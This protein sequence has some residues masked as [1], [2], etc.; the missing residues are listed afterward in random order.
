MSKEPKWIEQELPLAELIRSEDLKARDPDKT[1]ISAYARSYKNGDT[2]PPLKAANI[3]GALYLIDGWHRSLAAQKAGLVTLPVFTAKMTQGQAMA[4]AAMANAKHGR[5]IVGK[6]ERDRAVEMY[7][8]D[9]ANLSKSTRQIAKDLPGILTKSSAHRLLKKLKGEDEE[10]DDNWDA[11][12]QA[13][14]KQQRLEQDAKAAIKT[15]ET[16][17]ERLDN[18]Q[19]QRF[20]LQLAEASIGRLKRDASKL[21]PDPL[22][23]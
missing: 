12:R 22:D 8:Q 13:A 14:L 10:I 1:L 2:L 6:A 23:I 17:W 4:E 11:E 18:P 19:T 5:G 9:K 7:F 16:H 3:K 21:P 15:L 20:I